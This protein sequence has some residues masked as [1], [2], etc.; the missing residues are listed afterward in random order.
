MSAKEGRRVHA[1]F[2]GVLD[3]HVSHRKASAIFSNA[4][5]LANRE[6]N[7]GQRLQS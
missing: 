5:R 3:L 7:G 6:G 4:M 1:I 2:Y